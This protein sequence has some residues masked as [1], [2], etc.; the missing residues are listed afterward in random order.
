MLND[1]VGPA[2]D[3]HT[4][5]SKA[6]WLT[7]LGIGFLQGYILYILLTVI[8]DGKGIWAA[9]HGVYFI[10]LLLVSSLIPPVLIVGV[11]H[12]PRLRLLLWC[13]LLAAV[14][15]ALGYNDAWRVMDL[16]ALAT[17]EDLSFTM[18]PP[19]FEVSLFSAVFVFIGYALISA[20]EATHRWLAPYESYFE[21]SWKLALQIGLS[22][23]FAGVFFLILVLGANLFMLLKLN[24]LRDL[25]DRLWFNVPVLAMTFATGLHI[26]DVRPNIIRDIRTLLLTLLSWLLPLLVL[27]VAGFL[28]SLPVTG[29][30]PLWETRHATALLLGVAALEIVLINATYKNGM[31]ASGGEADTVP[32]ILRLCARLACLMLLALV[33]LAVY[34]LKLRIDQYGWTISRVSGAACALVALCY[35]LGYAW[36]ALERSGWLKRVASTNVLTSYITLALLVALFT[37]IADPARLAVASQVDRLLSGRIAPDEF[38]FRFL[39]FQSTVYGRNALARLQSTSVGPN[40]AAIRDRSLETEQLIDTEKSGPHVVNVVHNIDVRTPGQ[41]LPPSFMAND[42]KNVKGWPW[43]VPSCLSTEGDKCDAYLVR[44]SGDGRQNILLLAPRG[45]EGTLFDQDAAGT[46]QVLGRLKIPPGCVEERAAL[47]QGSY[48]AVPPLLPDLEINGRRIRVEAAASEPLECK[49]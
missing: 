41:N 7:R 18:D 9:T 34:A 6:L 11:G 47:M 33:A 16:Q 22:L 46:W 35:A 28:L 44:L 13:A 5:S 43:R 15:A 23:M 26:T 19:S 38:D 25:L 17:R 31:E 29:L 32:R 27:I 36:A 42:W 1:H 20:G 10:P 45:S 2:P 40:A 21:S 48:K 12:L 8:S 24:F 4:L 39:R 49:R 14:V 30:A 37:P 3:G